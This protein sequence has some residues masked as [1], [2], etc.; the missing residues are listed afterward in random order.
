M[1]LTGKTIMLNLGK[2]NMSVDKNFENIFNGLEFAIQRLKKNWKNVETIYLKTFDSVALPIFSSHK[3]E[4]IDFFSNKVHA[5][6]DKKTEKK[7]SEKSK[8]NK[9][10]IKTGN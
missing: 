4:M 2:I 7:N 3:K 9:K 5:V 8:S 10:K 6:V 1:Y